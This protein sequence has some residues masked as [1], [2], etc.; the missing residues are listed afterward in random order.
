[1]AAYTSIDIPKYQWQP[2]TP[3]IYHRPFLGRESHWY[4]TQPE[5]R[6]LFLGIHI[7]LNLPIALDEI[8]KAAGQGW[9]R[10]R[11]QHPELGLKTSPEIDGRGCMV[12]PLLYSSVSA[13][14]WLK[15]TL[16]RRFG[17]DAYDFEFAVSP[18]GQNGYRKEHA[19]GSATLLLYAQTSPEED[20]QVRDISLLFR[21]DH[22]YTDGIGLR[23][24]ANA[25]L[26][27]LSRELDEGPTGLP[28]WH[29]A[30]R[31]LSPPWIEMMNEDQR[32]DDFDQTIIK[33]EIELLQDHHQDN[34]IGI[35]LLPNEAGDYIPAYL[36]HPLTHH[37]SIT[38]LQ[39]VKQKLGPSYTITHLAHAAFILA[40]LRS[41]PPT[42]P[43]PDKT[44]NDNDT[45]V[46]T[47][48]PFISPLLTNARR[49]LDPENPQT[50][51][52][53]PICQA[54]GLI[55][56]PDYQDLLIRDEISKEEKMTILL[57]ACKASHASYQRI[58]ERKSML[59]ESLVR[60]ELMAESFP[61]VGS[62]EGKRTAD[63][64]SKPFFIICTS[65]S[66]F[67][68]FLLC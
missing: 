16:S 37:E 55:V 58:R 68:V 41:N 32:T 21:I 52:Y 51:D 34:D 59:T 40:I 1:M 24:L 45:I 20:D 10:L 46:P 12:C 26:N 47:H 14:Q 33:E 65:N 18:E 66:A 42:D 22:T 54:T 38:L 49:Y 53:T 5:N 19:R 30:A 35:L 17:Q 62:T 27:L 50:K 2:Q 63:P 6:E 15:R 36:F 23:I 4:N 7:K 11:I 28:P 44:F 61:E 13:S 29:F 43:T 56:F 31:N 57:K 25:F 64:V 8:V 9:L 60:E 67:Q 39:T 3:D 48:T